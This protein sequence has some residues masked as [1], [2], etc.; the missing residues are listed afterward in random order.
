VND[1]GPLFTPADYCSRRANIQSLALSACLLAQACQSL[2][3]ISSHDASE[4]SF[5]LTVSFY[6]SAYPDETTGWAT[7]SGRLQTQKRGA[8]LRL[9]P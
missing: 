2:W 4:R 6:S 1:L 3:L 7:L 5:I 9:L 8:F